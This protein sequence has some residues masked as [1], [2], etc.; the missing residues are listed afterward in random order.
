[1]DNPEPVENALG[2]ANRV[3]SD[4]EATQAYGHAEHASTNQA[5]SAAASAGAL[6][7]ADDV[8]VAQ[9]KKQMSDLDAYTVVA[10]T[11][12]Y[13][14]FDKSTLDDAA[15]A[16]LN[17][18]AQIAKSTNGYMIEVAAHA[19]RMGSREWNHKLI[20]A[21]TE[22]VAEYLRRVRDIPERRILVAVGYGAKHDGLTV[23]DPH[24]RAL[25]RRVDVKVLV[26]RSLNDQI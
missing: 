20:D 2:T 9:P 14:D 15:K 7:F 21:R 22:N 26:N 12:I 17:K 19:S 23:S 24:K 13:Y 3:A 5:G 18:L 10:E 4:A 1:M 6:G 25:N 16:D 8:A 11:G